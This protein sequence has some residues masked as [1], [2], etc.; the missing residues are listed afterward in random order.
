[1]NEEM[2]QFLDVFLDEATE[3][4]DLLE[5]D[6]LKLETAASAELVQG[7][8]RAA[9]TLKGSS[10]AMGFTSM[11]ELTHAME[12]ILDK[13]RHNK[14]TVNEEMV[15]ALFQALDTL[16]AMKEEIADNGMTDRTTDTE[17]RR[18]RAV[19][20]ADLS[21]VLPP[22]IEG[23]LAVSIILVITDGNVGKSANFFSSV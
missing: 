4:I 7:I 18:L 16:K 1:M 10:R 19:L 13:L 20:N 2:S 15:D 11:G 22:V 23:L 14:L 21:E 17:T 9:H 5:R 8:F 6:F 3:Q 12:D